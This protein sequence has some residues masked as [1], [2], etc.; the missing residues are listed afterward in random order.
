MAG[1]RSADRTGP[2]PTPFRMGEPACAAH[3]VDSASRAGR[4]PIR[5]A[6][7]SSVAAPFSGAGG[8]AA[9]HRYTGQETAADRS[10]GS[11][12]RMGCGG[13]RYAVVT[14][15]SPRGGT[16]TLIAM[17]RDRTITSGDEGGFDEHPVPRTGALLTSA[18]YAT[19]A[20][21]LDLLRS[22]HRTELAHRLRLARGF[23][24]SADNDDLLAV[25]EDTAVDEARIA[26]LEE[27]VRSASVVDG[28]TAHDGAAGLGSIVRVTD[29][30]GRIREYELVGRRSAE[31][32]RHEVTPASPVGQVLM[33]ARAG[34]VVR[35]ELPSGREQ[36]L[37]VLDVTREGAAGGA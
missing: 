19:L 10:R 17:A 16:D 2:A 36:A 33:G 8:R 13:S 26:L 22:R 20:G 34:D 1:S 35:V 37:R 31:T 27:L 28:A 18:E 15:W 25:L 3:R 12:A 24:G 29:D 9:H 4:H 21:E 32:R 7:Q 5:R 11:I 23:G 6:R 30:T 14:S